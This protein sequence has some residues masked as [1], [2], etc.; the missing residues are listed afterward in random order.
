MQHWFR[1][2]HSVIIGTTVIL[3]VLFAVVFLFTNIA[4][5]Q[6][7]DPYG[8]SYAEDVGLSTTD[9]RISV[10]RV[11]RTIL[12]V[13]GILALILMITAG[14]I[15]MT[16][17][18]NSARIELA[19]KIILNAL[20]GLLIIVMAFAIVQYIFKVLEGDG[21]GGPSGPICQAGQC[22]G[23]MKCNAQGTGYWCDENCGIDCYDI[24]YGPGP[25]PNNLILND[26]QTSHAG[27]DDKTDVYWCSKVQA[28]FNKNISQ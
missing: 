28:V 19:K 23:C 17:G 8:V 12:G 16:S 25:N 24:C 2:N 1:K 13:L 9:I 5:A 7:A 27:A 21:S 10:I 11:I 4:S 3:A 14:V 26:V 20:I 6:S 15:W 22:Y 18:G